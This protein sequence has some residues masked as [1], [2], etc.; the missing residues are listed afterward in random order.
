MV[1]YSDGVGRGIGKATKSQKLTGSIKISIT[2]E[3]SLPGLYSDKP[4]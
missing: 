3:D 4:L 2:S 1:G